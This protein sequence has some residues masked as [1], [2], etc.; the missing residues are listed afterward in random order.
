[1]YHNVGLNQSDYYL[2]RK[3]KLDAKRCE[4]INGRNVSFCPVG[5]ARLTNLCHCPG[6]FLSCAR[7]APGVRVCPMTFLLAWRPPPTVLNVTPWKGRDRCNPA[8][9]VSLPGPLSWTSSGF[10]GNSGNFQTMKTSVPLGQLD[11]NNRMEYRERS[12]KHLW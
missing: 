3:M 1:M 11:D 12:E 4:M 10:M 9:C 5:I 2:T 6:I 8:V 7:T